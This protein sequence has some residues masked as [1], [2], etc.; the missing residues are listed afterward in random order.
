SAACRSRRALAKDLARGRRWA[1]DRGGAHPRRDSGYHVPD[2]FLTRA[3][4]AGLG[5]VDGRLVIL[6]RS[7]AAT[8]DLAKILRGRGAQVEEVVAYRTLEGP[9]ES[10]GALHR[11]F[12]GELDGITFTS[13]STVR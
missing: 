7:D 10:R 4:A 1:R 8:P 11:A 9:A 13:G 2:Q 3:I 6:A 5:D 12:V